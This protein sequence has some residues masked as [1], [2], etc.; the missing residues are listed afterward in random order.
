MDKTQDPILNAL[1][2]AGEPIGITDENKKEYTMDVVLK[3]EYSVGGTA[4]IEGGYGTDHRYKAKGF[5]LLLHLR[6]GKLIA[7]L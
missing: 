1:Q 4:F 5:G 7:S 6:I 2:Q 3:R